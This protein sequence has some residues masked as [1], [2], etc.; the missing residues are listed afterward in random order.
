MDEKT[1]WI[2]RWNSEISPTKLPG[3]WKRKDGRYLVRARTKDQTTG[4]DKEIRKVLEVSTEA[5]ALKWLEDEIER[6]RR[7]EGAALHPKMRFADYAVSLA[8]RKR[9]TKEIKSAR[10]RERWKYTLEHLIGG[11]DD[12]TGLGELFID[13]IRPA[14][15]EAWRTGIARLIGAGKLRSDDRERLVLRLR[16]SHPEEGEAR[17]SAPFQRRRGHPRVRHASEHEVVHR[18]GAQRAHERETAALPRLHEGIVPRAVR[19]DLPGLRDR[20]SS[21]LDA[22]PPPHGGYARRPLGPRRDPRSE[23]ARARKNE[24]MKTTKAGLR[25]RITRVPVEVSSTC[26]TGID[27]ARSSRHGR[28]EASE[29]L[30]PA[31]DGS[32]RSESFLRKAVARRWEASLASKEKFTPRGLRRTFNDL[33][34]VAN[35]E[36]LVTRS[37]SGHLTEQMREH[38]STVSPSEQRESIGRVLRLV[39]SGTSDSASPEGTE[40]SGTHRGTQRGSSGTHSRLGVR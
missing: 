35:V 30:F 34:R 29:L 6:V 17:A 25:R 14:H 5:T 27:A 11:T 39:H 1:K 24:F 7:G 18:G 32:F 20:A 8:E 36:A 40:G 4:R 22:S 19:Y 38:Y 15:V 16:T 31:E 37:I 12:V 21:F 23:V 2:R 9:T 33:A 10:G 28:R 13:E 3:V 26:S